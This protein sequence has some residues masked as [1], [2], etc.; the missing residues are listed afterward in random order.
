ML[1]IVSSELGSRSNHEKHPF[2]LRTSTERLEILRFVDEELL[3]YFHIFKK[4]LKYK[5]FDKIFVYY[6]SVMGNN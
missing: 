5:I 2:L 4:F 3:K 1:A 6:I